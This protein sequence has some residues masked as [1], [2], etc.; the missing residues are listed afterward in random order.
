MASFLKFHEQLDL[1]RGV[2]ARRFGHPGAQITALGLRPYYPFTLPESNIIVTP[3]PFLEEDK[4]A[5][6]ETM[7]EDAQGDDVPQE[8]PQAT[9]PAETDNKSDGYDPLFD[10]MEGNTASV[11]PSPKSAQPSS[12]NAL[13]LA[14]SSRSRNGS[15]AERTWIPPQ[16]TP[17]VKHGV[18]LL[19]PVKYTDFSTDL[20]MTATFG[21]SI[22]L[23]DRRTQKN[24]GRVE[25]D[26]APP[27]CI[28]VNLSTLLHDALLTL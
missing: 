21:G 11:Q 4:P 6:P 8:E 12:S 26:R 28:S 7:E 9:T 15:T 23:W 5:I 20:L 14:M 24:V 19:D 22:F 27:W 3:P 16:V 13:G 17:A 2:M 10:D 1:D 18:G 25:N